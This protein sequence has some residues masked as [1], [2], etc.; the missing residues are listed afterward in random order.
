[1]QKPKNMFVLSPSKIYK[2]N[3]HLYNQKPGFGKTS[4]SAQRM[5]SSDNLRQVLPE[6]RQLM[7]V[8]TK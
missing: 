5:S 4:N 2:T 1:M 8:A 3:K 6:Q 7:H